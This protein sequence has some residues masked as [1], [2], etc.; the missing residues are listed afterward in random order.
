MRPRPRSPRGLGAL[1]CAPPPTDVLSFPPLPLRPSPFAALP[2]RQQ[3]FLSVP[4]PNGEATEVTCP[5]LRPPRRPL[6][7][8]LVPIA[9]G[10][11]L[12]Q[13]SSKRPESFCFE[14]GLKRSPGRSGGLRGGEKNALLRGVSPPAARRRAARRSAGGSV[15]PTRVAGSRGG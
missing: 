14:G 5:P 13:I 3:P 7:E 6:Q 10:P 15:S 11:R 2:A 1:P 8:E 9:S 4:A 12:Y